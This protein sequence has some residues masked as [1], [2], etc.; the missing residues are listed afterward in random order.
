MAIVDLYAPTVLLAHTG[1]EPSADDNA[2]TDPDPPHDEGECDRHRLGLDPLGL[3][4]VPALP[5]PAW[6]DWFGEDPLALAQRLACDEA[7]VWRIVLDPATGLPLD[8]GRAHRL[9]PHWIRRAL[10]AR[11]RGCRWPG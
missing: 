1:D 9:V 5:Q 3:A 8:V 2:S 6:L 7:N 10:H 4:G 11:D